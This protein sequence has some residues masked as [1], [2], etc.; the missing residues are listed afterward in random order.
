MLRVL[1][2]GLFAIFPLS[3][4]VS[5]NAQSVADSR[6]GWFTDCG[7]EAWI[8]TWIDT[9]RNAR[10]DPDESSL[11]GVAL[12]I[13]DSIR[14]RPRNMRTDA[15]GNAKLFLLW[16]TECNQ[17]RFDIAAVAPEGFE[18]TTAWKLVATN[19]DTLVFG[20]VRRGA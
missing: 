20:L 1:L 3:A 7:F 2:T 13:T 18:F 4:C 15:N 19:G 14:P 12:V 17:L 8:H 10:W 6:L 11:S 16:G 5:S 9:N